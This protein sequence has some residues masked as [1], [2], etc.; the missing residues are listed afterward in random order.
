MGVKAPKKGSRA[1]W[2]RARAARYV[3]EQHA[4]RLDGKGFTSFLAYKAGMTHVSMI[5]DAEGP[6]KGQEVIRSA[7]V[8][9]V[10]PFFVYSAAI[11]ENT[12]YGLKNIGEVPVT[13]NVPKDAQRAMTLAKKVKQPDALDKL[14][15]RTAQVRLICCTLPSKIGLKKTPDV[16]E[17]TLA[18][19]PAEQLA[20]AKANLGKE[21]HAKDVVQEGEWLDAI[22]VTKGQGWQGAVTRF[23]IALQPRKATQRR[24]RGGSLGPETQA[25]IMYTVPRPG[26]HGFHRRTDWNKRVLKIGEGKEFKNEFAH[27]G[28]ITGDYVLLDGSVPGPQKRA[29]RLRKA[30]RTSG[31]MKPEVKQVAAINAA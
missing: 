7:T 27:Y 19:S 22:G 20:F 24:R 5:A 31:I 4:W 8:L 10:P 26:Q 25:K 17:V 21:L 23:G 2:H 9:E 6:M 15:D 18:G 13:Q 1:F 16:F 29:I 14:A 28:R 30:I 3:P 11:Y 12:P